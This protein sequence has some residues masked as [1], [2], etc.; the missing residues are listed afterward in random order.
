MTGPGFSAA[1]TSGPVRQKQAASIK[2]A[3]LAVAILARLM[4]QHGNG[5][6]ATSGDIDSD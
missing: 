1:K 2:G 3:Q 6:I 4:Q 5:N